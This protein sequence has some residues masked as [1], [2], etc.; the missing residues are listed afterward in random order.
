M[1]RRRVGWREKTLVIAI[2]LAIAVTLY[3]SWSGDTLELLA[4]DLFAWR[5]TARA[6]PLAAA[7]SFFLLCVVAS[8]VCFP[9]KPLLGLSAG[10][11]FGWG[12]GLAL[13][14]AAFTIGSTVAMLGS[15]HL[16]RPWVEDRFGARV[17]RLREG[18]DRHR[19]AYLLMVRFNPFIP[20]WLVNLAVGLTDM[21]LKTYV[22]LTAIGIFPASFIYATMGS[23]LETLAAASGPSITLICAMLLL[24]LMPLIPVAAGA[25]RARARKRQA[26]RD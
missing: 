4:A 3:L 20:Y 22:P 15:R 25:W 14:L 5:E 17:A 12:Q 1:V 8:S 18:F 7:A 6:S 16:L 2:L 21:R 10:F 23:E 19:A 11:L 26:R 24:S 13:L 9:V